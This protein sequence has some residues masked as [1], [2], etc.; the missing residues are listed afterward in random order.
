MICGQWSTGF[1]SALEQLLENT[2]GESAPLAVFDADGTLWDTDA[3]ENFLS[4]LDA[5][6]LVHIA[7]NETIRQQY[8]R[9]CEQDKHSGYQWGAQVCAGLRID[10]VTAWAQD[11][12]Q[13]RT[14]PFEFEAM[15]SLVS[16]LLELQW[17]VM[18]V[19]ASPVWTVLPGTNAFGIAPEN[20]LALDVERRDDRLTEHLCRPFSMGE[21]KVD[22]IQK[23]VGQV[24]YLAA[25]NSLDDVPMLRMTGAMGVVVNP[26]G[27]EED[28]S[29][30]LGMAIQNDWHI[31]QTHS[32]Q[33]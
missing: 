11:S 20:V 15:R 16:R 22:C 17:R 14:A 8:D 27:D 31:L 4:H 9:R 1:L 21:G 13:K 29:S 25:G 30:L 28:F 3:N 2:M 10:Q 33:A 24:P 23:Y 19:S 32:R 7:E 18:V 12:Y 26:S 5:N 6:G